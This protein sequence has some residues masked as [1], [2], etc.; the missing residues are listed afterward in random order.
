MKIKFKNWDCILVQTKY[1]NNDRIALILEDANGGASPIATATINLINQP[2]EANEVI[3]K[4]YSE[5]EGMYNT[6]LKAGVIGEVKRRVPSGWVEGLVC[7]Y[8]LPIRTKY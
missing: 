3:I 2:L 4:D 7:D 8:L 6:L 5:N 1:G